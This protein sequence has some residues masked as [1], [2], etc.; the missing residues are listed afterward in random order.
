MLSL[1]NKSSGKADAAQTLAWHPN[2]R[3]AEQ[4][5]DTKTVRTKFFVNV[6]A[7]TVVAALLLFVTLRELTLAGLAK[8]LAEVETQIEQ[9]TKPSEKAIA[10]YKVFQEEEARFNDAYALVSNPFRFPDFLLHLGS[11]LPK[12]VKIRRVD[13]RGVTQALNISGSVRGVD[14][15]ASDVASEFVKKLQADPVLASNF[16]SIVLTTL[17]RNVA[18]GNMGFELV[19]TFKPAAKEAGKK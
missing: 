10:D 9:A 12:G 11:V 14:A 1:L 17:G 19:F 7:I 5:P 8:E 18:E 4:L 6:V 3:N 16:S 2:F 15:A 13:F